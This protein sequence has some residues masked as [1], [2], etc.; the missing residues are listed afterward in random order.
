MTFKLLR[1]STT[2]LNTLG[3]IYS[4][5]DLRRKVFKCFTLED[6]YRP[7]KIKHETRIPAGVYNLALRTYGRVHTEYLKKFGMDF[8]KGTIELKNVPNY[9]GILIHIGN[10]AKDTSGCILVGSGITP[11]RTLISSTLAYKKLYSEIVGLIVNEHK[12]IN[13][14]IVDFENNLV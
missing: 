6:T 2:E 14:E 5:D 1:F 12:Q 8:H 11:E 4:V 10:T 13:L 7:V 9:E 3:I